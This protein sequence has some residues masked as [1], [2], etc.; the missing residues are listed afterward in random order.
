MNPR[1]LQRIPMVQ[2]NE[3]NS[4]TMNLRRP[5]DFQMLP[6][7][8]G[9]KNPPYDCA[10]SFCAWLAGHCDFCKWLHGLPLISQE[11]F[12][13]FFQLDYYFF[14]FTDYRYSTGEW[15]QATV[16][17]MCACDSFLQGHL[18]LQDPKEILAHVDCPNKKETTTKLIAV[19]LT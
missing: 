4:A 9:K 15:V 10:I 12:C 11:L 17:K 19:P 8:I 16:E 3:R 14:H 2:C 1:N 13:L 7:D 6:V 18:Q 5:I